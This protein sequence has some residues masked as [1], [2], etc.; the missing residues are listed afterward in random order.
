M[1]NDECE[2]TKVQVGAVL[3]R[4]L[5]VT[6][7][8][9]LPSGNR[10]LA[11]ANCKL[12]TANRSPGEAALREAIRKWRGRGNR[13]VDGVDVTPACLHGVIVQD[14]LDEVRGDL[15]DIKA[16]LQWIRKLIVATI[17]TAGIGTLLRM[18]GLQ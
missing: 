13:K 11:T 3:C 7:V 8:W 15:E 14:G 5:P 10:R 4:Q 12:S 16:E 6:G 18:A 17:V 1:T 2:M 9:A